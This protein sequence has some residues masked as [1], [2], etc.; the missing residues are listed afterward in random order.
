MIP[1]FT[2][3]CLSMARHNSKCQKKPSTIFQSGFSSSSI[4]W[5]PIYSWV[6]KITIS[7]E[8][9][10]SSQLKFY[11]SSKTHPCDCPH[12][13]ISYCSSFC[14]VPKYR[15]T[16][17]DLSIFFTRKTSYVWSWVVL[18]MDSKDDIVIK[19]I[20]ISNGE[21]LEVQKKG[22]DVRDVTIGALE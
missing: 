4:K 22:W 14:L 12:L 9:F 10:Y 13:H 2:T 11:V 3:K 5:R 20:I 7:G 18:Q 6:L 15:Q 17:F 21:R 8:L 16:S 1:I 19:M